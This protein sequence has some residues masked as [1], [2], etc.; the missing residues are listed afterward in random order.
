MQWSIVL[1]IDCI[2]VG[3]VSQ[4]QFYNL[5]VAILSSYVQYRISVIVYGVYGDTSQQQFFDFSTL[6]TSSMSG[7]RGKWEY[8]CSRL[9]GIGKLPAIYVVT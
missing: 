6:S 5:F 4:C 7:G 8:I 2:D 3:T 1:I 9:F